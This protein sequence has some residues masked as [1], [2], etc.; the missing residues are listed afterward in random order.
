MISFST[1][2]GST[3][4]ETGVDYSTDEFGKDIHHS[5]VQT[6]AALDLMDQVDSYTRLPTDWDGYGAE[7]PS[8][9]IA[10]SAKSAITAF[11]HKGCLPTKVM[12]GVAD[13]IAMLWE[14]GNARAHLEISVDEGWEWSIEY[15]AGQITYH[16]AEGS[17]SECAD[18][19]RQTIRIALA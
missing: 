13:D 16:K 14:L 6:P 19:V 5:E 10:H 9:E 11:D 7:A 1:P 15:M 4:L 8:S 18:K 3:K 17:A 12:P 2:L